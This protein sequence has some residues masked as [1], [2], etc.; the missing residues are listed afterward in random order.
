MFDIPVEDLLRSFEGDAPGIIL[1]SLRVSLTAVA[2]ASLLGLPLG[3][4]VAVV[5][6]PGR[7][8][9]VTA[10]NALMGLPAVLVGLVVYLS[11]SRSGPLGSF[12]LLFTPAAMIIAQTFLTTPLIAALTRQ[13][14]EDAWE[15]HS[16]ILRSLRLSLP[17]RVRVLLWDCRFSVLAAVLAGLGRAMSEVGTVMI[18]GGNIDGFT[19][20][21]TTA[22]AL[23]TSKGDLPLAVTLGLVLMT[24][25]LLL[26]AIVSAVRGFAM[27]RHGG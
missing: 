25:V 15:R 7:A 9:V 24:L 21:M 6:F 27:K 18:V 5:R 23:E 14:V 2:F 16:G 19:R 26:N 1:L 4:L 3:A 11:L 17:A 8:L 22:I 20:V 12:G 13:T 10:L